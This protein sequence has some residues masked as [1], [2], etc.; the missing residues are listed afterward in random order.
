V[1]E[2]LELKEQRKK[3]FD[4]LKN[5]LEPKILSKTVSNLQ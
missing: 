5:T 1:Q 3:E 2:L 4:E